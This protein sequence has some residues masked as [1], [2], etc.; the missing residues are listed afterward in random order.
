MEEY[1]K[2]ETPEKEERPGFFTGKREL[3]FAAGMLIC[4]IA[5]IN[6]IAFG[7]FHLGFAIAG[8]LSIL[9]SAWYLLGKGSRPSAYGFTVIGLCIAICA[10]FAWSDDPAVKFVMVIF[11]LGGVNLGLSVLCGKNRYETGYF[12]SLGDSFYTLF[13]LGFG[14]LPESYHGLCQAFRRSGTVGQKGGAVV[15]GLCIAVPILGIMLILL[16]RADAAFEGLLDLLPTP[17]L[18]ELPATLLFGTGLAAVYYTRGVALKNGEKEAPAVKQRKGL[19]PLTLNTVLCAVC[20]VYVVYLLS[21]LTYLTGGFAGNLPESYTLA[22]YARRGFF[23]M[24]WLCVI[25]LF[26]ICLSLGLCRQKPAPRFTRLLCCF[27]GVVTLFL[28]ATASAK[29]LLYIGGY[30]LTRLRVLTQVIMVFLAL[31]TVLVMI[32]L[33]KPSF[34]YMQTVVVAALAIC[35]AVSWADVDTQVA[36]Y[37]V[38]AYLSGKLEAVDVAHLSGLGDGALPALHRLA[39][40]AEEKSVA[41]K[42]AHVLRMRYHVASQDFR[43]WNYIHQVGTNYLSAW[44]A[45]TDSLQENSD[46]PAD[47]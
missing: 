5:L 11:L 32:W 33:F 13:N 28:I 25:N 7:G 40:E 29:M 30:G 39:L 26:V 34:R 9:L 42:A 43:D 47:S 36:N 12:R 20:L 41:D 19:D 21:Q 14:K 24:A 23:E 4:G 8:S 37:N 45:D 6:F 10:S 22:D 1:Q 35:A 16:G 17:D 15:L 27:I 31:V 44:Q 46:D 2:W 38:D 18:S 3:L